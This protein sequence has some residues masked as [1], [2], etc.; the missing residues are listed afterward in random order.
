MS[1][2]IVNCCSIIHPRLLEPIIRFSPDQ[3]LRKIRFRC[4]GD[5]V[6]W[7]ENLHAMPL[8][9][10]EVAST[11][12]VA[13]ASTD[14]TQ[15]IATGMKWINFRSSMFREVQLTRTEQRG[16]PYSTTLFGVQ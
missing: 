8:T 2:M 4:I 6:V 9:D 1:G 10:I 11:F 16:I 5:R 14:L 3:S 12:Q 13:I 7:L 15:I